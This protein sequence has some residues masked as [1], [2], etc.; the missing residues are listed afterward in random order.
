MSR[1]R[2]IRG[3]CWNAFATSGAGVFQAPS[4]YANSYFGFRAV[5]RRLKNLRGA[6]TAPGYTDGA[7]GHDG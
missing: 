5:V 4:T 1:E 6:H 3:K 7:N 2:R